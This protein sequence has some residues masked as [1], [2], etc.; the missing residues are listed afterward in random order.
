MQF[1]NRVL[2]LIELCI[3]YLDFKASLLKKKVIVVS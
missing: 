3:A 2:V 1:T